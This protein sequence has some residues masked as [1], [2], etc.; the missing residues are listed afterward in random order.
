MIEICHMRG[1]KFHTDA[2]QAVG[3]IPVNLFLLNADYMT[4]SS[5]KIGG[6]QGVGA[7]ITT[8]DNTAP[9]LLSG[10]GQE[11]SKRAGTENVA[12][13]IGFGEAAKHAKENIDEFQKLND[14]QKYL[15]SKLKEIHQDIVIYGE[16]VDRICNTTCCSIPGA[17]AETMIIAFDLE[18]I[19]ISSGSACSSGKV[20]E[21]HVLKAM[22][23]SDK[24]M[25]GA[26]R[27]SY[28]WGTTREDIDKFLT[29]AERIIKR[30]TA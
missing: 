6:P 29:A 22:G 25:K 26:L 9:V 27:I 12:G 21:S 24:D 14:T 13:I 23:A 16:N 19:A 11:K 20:T 17:S 15:E 7:L 30:V 1:I 10:G 4:I 5:H 3:R 2:T 8:N 28:G 18:G